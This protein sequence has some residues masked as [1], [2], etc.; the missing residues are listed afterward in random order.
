MILDE[1]LQMRTPA[2]LR[3]SALPERR[4]WRLGNHSALQPFIGGPEVRQV[5]GW[6]YFPNPQVLARSAMRKVQ[7]MLNRNLLVRFVAASAIVLSIAAC[8][9]IQGRESAAQYFDDTAIT[10]KVKSQIFN[11]P[12][13][14]TTQISVETLLGDVQLSGF[15]DSPI[16]KMK[17]G[18]LAQNVEGVRTVRNDL[19]VR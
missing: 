15:V 17:A 1:P 2:C 13:L 10:T 4:F 16:S 8:D 6:T 18:Q 19:V 14:K 9:T 12:T 3:G 7:P 11:E 5:S